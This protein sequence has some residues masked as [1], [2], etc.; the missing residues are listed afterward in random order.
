[1][2]ETLTLYELNLWRVYL[3]SQPR[4]ELREDWRTA[5]IC[6]GIYD[7]GASFSKSSRNVPLDKFLLKFS[8]PEKNVLSGILGIFGK[9]VPPEKLKEMRNND[10]D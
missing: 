8:S 2:I 9:C 3:Q 7:I 6:K 4:G 1:L 5:Q 10:G